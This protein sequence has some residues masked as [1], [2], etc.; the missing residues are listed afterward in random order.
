LVT[1]RAFEQGEMLSIELPLDGGDTRCDV[2]ACVVHC[3]Q[4]CA[5]EWSVG[6][7]FSRELS[8]A[9]LKALRVKPV[10]GDADDQRQWQRFEADVSAT[11]QLVATAEQ[12]PRPAK[13]VN[14]SVAGIGLMVDRA[15]ENGALLSVELH[16]A[17][18]TVERTMLA[19]VVHVNRQ[20][21]GQW[22]LGCNFIRSLG[23]KDLQAL[24][25]RRTDAL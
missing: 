20:P 13:V 4:T 16:N 23:E 7:N 1:S 17:S 22:A 8:A 5:G 9:D 19:C 10:V 21:K 18:G 11:F 6:C 3:D 24:L 25:A 15:V 12:T 2:L 14:L